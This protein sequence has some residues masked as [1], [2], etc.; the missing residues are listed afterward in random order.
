[1][2]NKKGFVYL[3]EEFRNEER[4][5]K[6]GFTTSTVE[7][8]AKSMQTGNSDEII[9]CAKYFTP[10]YLKLEK[11]LHGH[12]ASTHKRGE[13]FSMSD[14]QALTFEKQC[15]EKDDIINFMISS[16]NPFY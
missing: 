4:A 8:R 5:F 13:W 12:F 1:M 9:I 14:E 10:N 7:K 16:E 2:G 3:L 6:I 15:I 11:M